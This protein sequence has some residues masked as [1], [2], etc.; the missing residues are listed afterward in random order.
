M[1]RQIYYSIDRNSGYEDSYPMTPSKWE[2]SYDVVRMFTASK[3]Y[4][5]WYNNY[6]SEPIKTCTF[7]ELCEL[8]PISKEQL[9]DILF[10]KER[11]LFNIYEEIKRNK[12]T[13]IEYWETEVGYQQYQKI[14][15]TPATDKGWFAEYTYKEGMKLFKNWD[16]RADK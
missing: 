16:E 1:K 5:E 9:E 8:C 7:E 4:A 11:K 15:D 2:Y 13:G 6:Y 10:T 14:S 3:E 12:E